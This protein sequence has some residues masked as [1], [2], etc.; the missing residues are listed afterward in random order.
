MELNPSNCSNL[1]QLALKGL[2]PVD[3]NIIL[4]ILHRPNQ[5]HKNASPI[6]VKVDW[7]KLN[8]ADR[9]CSSHSLG[10]LKSW[11]I[12]VLQNRRWTF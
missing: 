9:H 4:G 1:E 8:Q 3:Y 12:S 2:K 10:L 7:A 11:F 6:W 5:V